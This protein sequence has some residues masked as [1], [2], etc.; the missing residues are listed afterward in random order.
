MTQRVCHV[1]SA[2]VAPLCS[3]ELQPSLQ[4]NP[5]AIAAAATR[6]RHLLNN[7][8]SGSSLTDIMS[9]TYGIGGIWSFLVVVGLCTC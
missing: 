4:L 2:S 9:Y 3:E 7:S 5:I 8:S 6:F 1:T